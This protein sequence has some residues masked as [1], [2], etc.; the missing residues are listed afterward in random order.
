[1]YALRSYYDDAE[2]PGGADAGADVDCD[3]L[4]FAWTGEFPEESLDGAEP[5]ATFMGLGDFG[6]DLTV[7]DGDLVITSY[8]IHYTK[9]YDG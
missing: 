7:G 1:M 6:I 4:S 8:S 9:L 2:V 3:E 5:T